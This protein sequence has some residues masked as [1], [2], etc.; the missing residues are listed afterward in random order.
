MNHSVLFLCR[1]LNRIMTIVDRHETI[2]VS[3]RVI[4]HFEWIIKKKLIGFIVV[5]MWEL[6]AFSVTFSRSILISW[7]NR[8]RNNETS[9]TMFINQL[10]DIGVLFS[11]TSIC[12]RETVQ[13]QIASHQIYPNR[14][15]RQSVS[16]FLLQNFLV[17]YP[18]SAYRFQYVN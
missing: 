1:C 2:I 14:C 11:Q 16:L 17:A 8:L 15:Y 6:N 18:S 7:L 12:N 5:Y 10:S 4:L 13:R 9:A 3:Y